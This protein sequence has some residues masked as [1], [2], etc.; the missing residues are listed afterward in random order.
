MKPL[1]GIRIIDLTTIIAGPAATSILAQF[2]ADIIKI[3]RAGGEESR[4]WGKRIDDVSLTFDTFNRGKRSIVI[5][6]GKDEGKSLLHRLMAS[7]NV[8][9]HNVRPSAARR[10][11]IDKDALKALF[12]RLIYCAISGYGDGPEGKSRAGVDPAIQ[13]FSGMME[14]TGH[15]G[16][17]PTRCP[18][19]L[20]DMETGRWAAMSIMAALMRGPVDEFIDIELALIDSAIALMPHQASEAL[21]TGERPPRY[22]SGNPL[23]TPHEVLAAQDRPI[24]V[25]APHAG[26]VARTHRSDRSAPSPGRSELRDPGCAPGESPRSRPGAERDIRAASGRC[27]DGPAATLEHRRLRGSES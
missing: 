26:Q 14:M 15:E 19:S 24:F 9:I 21:L 25:G 17:P 16:T 23:A 1:A 22:G 6:L 7:A 3:E 12:P 5:D 20:I 11:G 18:I 2:G 10:L 27:L 4:L 13:A 8:F